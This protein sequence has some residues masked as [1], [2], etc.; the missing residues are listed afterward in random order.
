MT[1][2]DILL[3]PQISASL[4]PH[5]KNSFLQYIVIKTEIHN[6]TICKVRNFEAFTLKWNV[7]I[8]VLHSKLR[9]VTGQAG[10]KI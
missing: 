2:N 1:Y 10:R 8:K 5:Q 6:W 3:Y 4:N 7:F 9:S